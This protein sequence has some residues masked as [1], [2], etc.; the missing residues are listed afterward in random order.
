MFRTCLLAL[1]LLGL[2]APAFAYNIRE[3]G[4]GRIIGEFAPMR[5]GGTG[6][7]LGCWYHY[8]PSNGARDRSA[9]KG[10]TSKDGGTTWTSPDGKTTYRHNR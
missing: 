2:A 10:W 8:Y 1:T 3:Y 4:R 5:E 9:P 7:S 6:R